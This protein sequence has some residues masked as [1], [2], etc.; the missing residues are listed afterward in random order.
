[1]EAMAV[2]ND[3][4]MML[5]D[6]STNNDVMEAF[7]DHDDEEAAAMGVQPDEGATSGMPRA[8]LTR[9]CSKWL[10]AP[11]PIR[12]RADK[13]RAVRKYSDLYVRNKTRLYK[14]ATTSLEQ[15]RLN[16]FQNEALLVC[17]PFIVVQAPGLADEGRRL[18]RFSPP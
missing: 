11:L 12:S 4:P 5:Y 16:H 7:F 10:P 2:D 15:P 1:M 17:H 13:G 9:S 18:S 8:F 6:N 14:L 3:I